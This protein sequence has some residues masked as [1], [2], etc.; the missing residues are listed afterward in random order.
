M[1][2]LAAILT[3]L[4]G[5]PAAGATTV[6]I[7]NGTLEMPSPGSMGVIRNNESVVFKA[8]DA[9]A[10]K[11]GGKIVVAFARNTFLPGADEWAIV[12][13]PSDEPFSAAA[14][15]RDPDAIAR[16]LEAASDKRSTEDRV[17]QLLAAADIDTTGNSELGIVAKTDR[18]VTN[19]AVARF[20]GLPTDAMPLKAMVVVTTMI[21]L[22]H[23][24]VG[25]TVYRPLKNGKDIAKARERAIEWAEDVAK[26]SW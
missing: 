14:F 5:L 6:T 1:K 2:F 22:R 17:A 16:T 20:I 3:L 21:S 24:I 19:V 7:G 15:K 25:L 26:A 23:R 4:I 12:S 9:D 8:I 10:R 11:G 18:Y 13:L